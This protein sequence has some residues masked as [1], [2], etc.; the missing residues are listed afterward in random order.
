MNAFSGLADNKV[1]CI[2]WVICVFVQVILVQASAL[3]DDAGIN[4]PFHTRALSGEQW[5]FTLVSGCGSLVW[6]WF[7]AFFG[8][9]IKCLFASDTTWKPQGAGLVPQVR[10]KEMLEIE[11]G[12]SPQIDVINQ[13]PQPV[14]D[15]SVLEYGGQDCPV[16]E[17]IIKREAAQ[18]ALSSHAREASQARVP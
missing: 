15:G 2:I 9:S 1:F 3:W 13:E 5:V 14:G 11:L 6:Y 4:K 8:T 7:V 12:V 16:Q 17:K 10:S 18:V